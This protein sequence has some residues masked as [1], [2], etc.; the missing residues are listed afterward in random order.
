[1]Y[2]NLLF[3]GSMDS[4]H[5]SLCET[6]KKSCC[7]LGVYCYDCITLYFRNGTYSLP[8]KHTNL[9]FY[10]FICLG[11]WN[12]CIVIFIRLY[13][14]SSCFVHLSLSC[15]KSIAHNEYW[16]SIFIKFFIMQMR[17]HLIDPSILPEIFSV[18]VLLDYDD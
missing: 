13:L 7:M 16:R 15:S 9:F 14:N 2:Y 12:S 8:W 4:H 11:D 3:S 17:N 10:S 18:C 5:S 1:M 6:S